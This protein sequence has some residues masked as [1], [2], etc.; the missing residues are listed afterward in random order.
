MSSKFWHRKHEQGPTA[1][2]QAW[3]C[4]ACTKKYKTA[5]GMLADIHRASE[6]TSTFARAKVT[7][8]DV[9]DLRAMELETKRGSMK[10]ISPQKLYE[11]IPNTEPMRLADIMRPLANARSTTSR[12]NLTWA[13]PPSS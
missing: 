10:G 11:A 5:H 6:C 3:C 7:D 13:G 8:T 2:K 1:A 12:T 9:E 4:C